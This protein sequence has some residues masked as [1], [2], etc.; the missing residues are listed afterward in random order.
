MRDLNKDP[1]A[2]AHVHAQGLREP[3][4]GEVIPR[5]YDYCLGITSDYCKPSYDLM[6][7]G[8][9]C[10]ASY[11]NHPKDHQAHGEGLS[12]CPMPVAR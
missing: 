7:K 10:S 3:G 4:K 12:G 8:C 2:P 11:S 5:Q 1:V 6:L 9:T